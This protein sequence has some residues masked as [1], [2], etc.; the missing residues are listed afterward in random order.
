V[1]KRSP[2]DVV[3]LH[4]ATLEE[5]IL[6]LGSRHANVILVAADTVDGR[7]NVW[8]NYRGSAFM[9]MGLC[10][11]TLEVIKERFGE[12]SPAVGGVK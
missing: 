2:D 4:E 10:A 6:E 12:Y 3:H 7:D 9:A 11:K 8:I 1:V 5:I